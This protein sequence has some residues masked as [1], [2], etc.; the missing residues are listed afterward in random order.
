MARADA[1]HVVLDDADAPG[2]TRLAQALEDL[3]RAV[4]VGVE[5]AHDLA[6][7]GIELARV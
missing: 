2:L 3:L 1:P 7:E 4:R 5:P 6:L